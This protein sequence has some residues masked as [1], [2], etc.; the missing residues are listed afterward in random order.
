M[1]KTSIIIL[2][3]F[4][5]IIFTGQNSFSSEPEKR[6]VSVQPTQATPKDMAASDRKLMLRILERIRNS[7]SNGI[8]DISSTENHC[9]GIVSNICENPKKSKVKF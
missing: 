2:A 9:A 4:I 6:T 8:L 3:V 7:K 1:K 5:G